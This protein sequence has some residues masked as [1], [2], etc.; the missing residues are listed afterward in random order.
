MTIVD[1]E[2]QGLTDEAFATL[3]TEA[4]TAHS[5]T[6]QPVSDETADAI[7][8]LLKMAPTEMNTQPLRVTWVRSR[9]ARESLAEVMNE[10]NKAKTLAAPLTAILSMDTN[11]HHHLGALAPW[12][13]E[14][15]GHF[16][17]NPLVRET[18]AR[19]N[20]FIQVG[21][22]IMAARALGLSA[23]PMS[24]FNHEALDAR[25]HGDSGQ[26]A[27]VVVNLGYPHEGSFRPRSGRL[28]TETATRTL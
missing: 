19:N 22:F 21:Y 3:F 16:E 15:M 14:R 23:G 27:L 4:H 25:F 8:E 11:W 9:E 13:E 10:G 1:I 20:S 17:E 2:T 26:H 7:Y 5:F 6:E 18:M 24:G 28:S 12:A